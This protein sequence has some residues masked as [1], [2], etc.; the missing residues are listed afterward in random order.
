MAQCKWSDKFM[1]RILVRNGLPYVQGCHT[2]DERGTDSG[3]ETLIKSQC[4][5]RNSVQ[6]PDIRLM[7]VSSLKR[8]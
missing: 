6:R 4:L 5:S 2:N 8:D 3:V 7:L 1:D